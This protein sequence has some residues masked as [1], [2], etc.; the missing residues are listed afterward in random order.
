MYEPKLQ[1][2]NRIDA[3]RAG[4]GGSIGLIVGFVY[5]QI[6]NLASNEQ[7]KNL[8]EENHNLVIDMG[9]GALALS[10]I[11]ALYSVQARRREFKANP[12]RIAYQP[13][14]PKRIER[15]QID[16]SAEAARMIAE[17]EEDLGIL[18]TPHP[19]SVS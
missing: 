8:A 14:E 18:P 4:L 19:G 16:V 10:S 6:Y 7:P 15:P 11:Y 17:L 1:K 3:M 9:L 13:F 12:L 5:G 2:F